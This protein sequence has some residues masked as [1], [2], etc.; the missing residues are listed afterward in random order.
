MGFHFIFMYI[1]IYIYILI[2]HTWMICITK[3]FILTLS[4]PTLGVDNIFFNSNN[5]F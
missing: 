4:N 2:I 3:S 1:C 5:L